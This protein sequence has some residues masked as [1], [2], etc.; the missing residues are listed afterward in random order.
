MSRCPCDFCNADDDP[1]H[2]FDCPHIFRDGEEQFEDTMGNPMCE[3]C[4]EKLTEKAE[5]LYDEMKEEGAL[6][7]EVAG[8]KQDDR[9]RKRIDGRY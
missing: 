8:R 7:R 5:A 4:R 2:C 3:S 9:E 1:P 6:K